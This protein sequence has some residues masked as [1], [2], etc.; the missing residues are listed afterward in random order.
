MV[1][2]QKL[3]DLII[4]GAT[5]ESYYVA[6]QLKA[7]KV[8][9][10]IAVISTTFNQVPEEELSEYDT[11]ASKIV[12]IEYFRGMIKVHDA[13]GGIYCGKSLLIST[14]STPIVDKDYINERILE[15]AKFNDFD[16][17]KNAKKTNIVIIS[18]KTQALTTAMKAAKKFKHVYICCPKI[19][20]KYGSKM[21]EKLQ[22]FK[23]ITL[24]GN[25]KVV[26]YTA[27]DGKLQSVILDTY[28]SIKCGLLLVIG[29]R[30]P[31]VPISWHR[32]CSLDSTGAIKVNQIGQLEHFENIYAIGHCASQYRADR[33]PELVQQI[34]K[35]CNR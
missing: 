22:E 31:T 2:T 16:K 5:A 33:I 18:E 19:T 9:A 7:Q 27:K 21:E 12:Y 1:E 4:I 17:V 32:I 34:L 8:N 26:D 30:R 23:N 3:Y 10:S 25:C 13:A 28:S 14:G 24:L 6:R 35:N 29:E 20:I 15:V 11:L